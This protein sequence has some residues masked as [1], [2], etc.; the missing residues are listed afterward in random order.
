MLIA[1]TTESATA[2]RFEDSRTGAKSSITVVHAGNIIMNSFP[3]T[4][5]GGELTSQTRHERTNQ[6]TH[7]EPW[8]WPSPWHMIK[9]QNHGA[10]TP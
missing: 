7:G 4:L 10:D 6:A 1:V 2:G 5:G 8:D 3:K 9:R